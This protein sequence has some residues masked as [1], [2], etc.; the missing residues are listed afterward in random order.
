MIVVLALTVGFLGVGC[1]TTTSETTAAETT[2]AAETTAAETTA[3]AAEPKKLKIGYAFTYGTHPSVKFIVNGTMDELNSDKWAEK[4]DIEVVTVDAG[5]EDVDTKLTTALEDVY[6][7]DVDGLVVFAGGCGIAP[8]TPIKNLF[9]ANNIPV[10]QE[11]WC[12]YADQIDYIC[13][14]QKDMY[15]GGKMAGEYSG[16]L[17]EAGSK[18]I[19]MVTIAGDVTTP[20][21]TS[22]EG[23]NDAMTDLGMNVLPVMRAESASIEV[24]RKLM[25]DLLVSDPDIKGVFNSNMLL[26]LG[27][28]QALKDANKVG[29]V[30]IATFDIDATTYEAIKNGEICCAII[31][32]LYGMGQVSAE[33][34]M[35]FLD[36]QPID[37]PDVYLPPL[38]VNK[39]TAADF[40]DD[41][42]VQP[43]E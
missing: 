26:S 37:E 29:E 36:G 2:V 9:N 20:G 16:A 4:Y 7:Q 22:Y 21:T 15:G 39:D 13:Y 33:G 18:V 3:A 43:A 41:P 11:D 1:K 25:E 40:A 10:A 35:K 42:Q 17:M 24:G 12:A 30:L 8:G 32:D 28:L 34:L 31:N 5:W 23:Y 19:S 6:A 38:N 14:A 27:A